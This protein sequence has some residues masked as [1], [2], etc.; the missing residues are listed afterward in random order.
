M[1][2]G[3]SLHFSGPGFLFLLTFKNGDDTISFPFLTGPLID[4]N[5]NEHLSSAKHWSDSVK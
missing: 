1:T 3:R 5:V 4:Q 2:L